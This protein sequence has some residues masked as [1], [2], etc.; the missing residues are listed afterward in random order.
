MNILTIS[1]V[2][3]KLVCLP[4]IIIRMKL[5]ILKTVIG[6]SLL[7]GAPLFREL[8]ISMLLKLQKFKYKDTGKKDIRRQWNITTV[9]YCMTQK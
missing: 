9:K 4:N 3:Y 5:L 1:H 7:Y 6:P 8:Y 2:L